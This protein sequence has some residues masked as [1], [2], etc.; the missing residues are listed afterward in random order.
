MEYFEKVY[1]LG[2]FSAPILVPKPSGSPQKDLGKPS[3]T[4]G[5]VLATI[6]EAIKTTQKLKGTYEYPVANC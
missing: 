3:T 6:N 1:I 2:T 4:I 5:E